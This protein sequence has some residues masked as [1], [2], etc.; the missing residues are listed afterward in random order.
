MNE[1]SCRNTNNLPSATDSGF[2]LNLKS[3]T[4]TWFILFRRLLNLTVIYT[5]MCSYRFMCLPQKR[6]SKL[7]FLITQILMLFYLI[8]QFNR[9]YFFARLLSELAESLGEKKQIWQFFNFIQNRR[10]WVKLSSDGIARCQFFF[11]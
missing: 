2:L 10:F 6:Y 5:K 8:T 9:I 7:K 4:V 1:K 11:W 3:V